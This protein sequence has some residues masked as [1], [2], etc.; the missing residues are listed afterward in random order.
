[1][2]LYLYLRYI[3]K[4]SSQPCKFL[5]GTAKRDEKTFPPGS[6]TESE[7]RSGTFSS[8][9]SY[10]FLFWKADFRT[11]RRNVDLSIAHRVPPAVTAFNVEKVGQLSE[12]INVNKPDYYVC[13][14]HQLLSQ[15]QFYCFDQVIESSVKVDKGP[16]PVWWQLEACCTLE[17]APRSCR[18]RRK[19]RPA[20][21]LRRCCI[22]R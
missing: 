17:P 19:R 11:I 10:I 1:M 9:A 8:S 5:C 18:A 13:N 2:Y 16:V 14:A 15:Q 21:R 3:S 12:H 22:C 6:L 20:C 7:W 4:V